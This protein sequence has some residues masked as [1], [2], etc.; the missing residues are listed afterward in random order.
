MKKIK[1][2]SFLIVL[3][4][5]LLTFSSCGNIQLVSNSTSKVEVENQITN[6]VVDYENITIADL[7]SAVVNTSN[8][9]ENA[10]IGVTLKATYTSII[11]GRPVTSED[12]ESVGSG[13]IYK[14]VENYDE[15][16]KLVSFTYYAV[17]NRHV[18]TG[19]NSSYE[20]NIYAYL[21]NEEIEI[22]ASLLGKDEK[23]DM[24]VI[25]FEHTT[26]IDPVE[27]GDSDEIEKGQFVI[28]I[29]NPD[30]YD[31][32]G[33]VTFGVVS[34]ELRHIS[35]DTDDDGVTD[36]H[37]TYVQ[38]DAAINPGNSGGGLFT[39]DGKL[40]GI[41]TLKIVSDEVDN[42]GFAIPSNVIKSLIENYIEKGEPIIRPQLGIT[43][44]EVK[45]LSNA[46]IAQNGLK[47]LPDI[48][49][50]TPKYGL[51]VVSIAPGSTI[52]QSGMRKDDILLEFDGEKLTNMNIMSAKLNALTEYFIGTQV[53]ITYYSRS[54]NKIVTESV[55]L[56]TTKK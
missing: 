9:L 39:I 32:Y 30:G 10:V 43:T 7:E 35:D 2:F 51:Y 50:A 17:T 16:N 46:Y 53:E 28:A 6:K 56:Q 47:E 42:M 52:S 5:A 15:N 12:S 55:T 24:A 37:G 36:F 3:M 20:Y 22:K 38:H 8:M 48:Y 27:F 44:V 4:I 21:G 18:I 11:N 1:R 34:G 29:G 54:Q 13:V 19:N 31:Y 23:V 25:T 45:H 33:S 26:L 14:R 49:G 41:N 40:I